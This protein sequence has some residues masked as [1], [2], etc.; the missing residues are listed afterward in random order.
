[1]AEK[2][3]SPRGA[4]EVNGERD[5]ARTGGRKMDRRK[6]RGSDLT[7]EQI[8]RAVEEIDQETFAR[9]E[10]CL[11]VREAELEARKKCEKMVA[12]ELAEIMAKTPAEQVWES[13]EKVREKWESETK[14]AAKGKRGRHRQGR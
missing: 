6:G 9:E 1:M 13:F 7:L 14:A 11:E 2:K 5:R 3:T 10:M 4:K 12:E 8:R